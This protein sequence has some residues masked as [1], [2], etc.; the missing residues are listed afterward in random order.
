MGN[1]IRWTGALLCGRL[2]HHGS[3][4]IVAGNGDAGND[5]GHPREMCQRRLMDATALRRGSLT[6]LFWISWGSH[7]DLLMRD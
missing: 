7:C 4:I 5:P 3:R 2:V 1:R 6:W